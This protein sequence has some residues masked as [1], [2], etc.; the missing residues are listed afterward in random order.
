MIKEQY[1]EEMTSFSENLPKGNRGCFIYPLARKF[2]AVQLYL[3]Q[4][5]TFP[6]D[7]N[8]I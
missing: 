1:E 6:K 8:E 4:N 3:T 5:K 7:M 2:R